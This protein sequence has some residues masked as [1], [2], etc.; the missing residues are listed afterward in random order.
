MANIKALSTDFTGLGLANSKIFC[1]S[2]Q[3]F[4]P[5]ISPVLTVRHH[6]KINI[7]GPDAE[8]GNDCIGEC[9]K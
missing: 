2:M 4:I 1:I 6:K 3:G 7:L 8:K 9:E 5:A